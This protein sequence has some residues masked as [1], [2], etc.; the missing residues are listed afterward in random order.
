MPLIVYLDETGDHGLEVVGQ[1]LPV[2]VL[3]MIICDTAIYS[4]RIV[5]SFLKFKFDYFGNDGVILHSRDIRKAQGDFTFLADPAKRQP[6][7]ER[8]NRLMGESEYTLIASVIRKQRLKDQYG[9]WAYN[10]YHLAFKFCLERLL[11]LLEGVGQSQVQLVA[12]ARGRRE[13][14]ELVSSFRSVIV[15]GT[16]YISGE[17]FAKIN[18]DLSFKPKKAN[19]IGHQIADLAGYPIGRYVAGPGKENPAY[20]IIKKKFYRG[21]GLIYGLKTFPS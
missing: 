10:P 13:D 2:F 12:E 21:P 14:D 19:L 17:R 4:E 11:P 3:T 6:F 9:H 20:E 15:R 16:E 7:Y 18:F 8:I 1:D 5:P